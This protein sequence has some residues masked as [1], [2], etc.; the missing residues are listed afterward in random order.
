MPQDKQNLASS[1]RS[2]LQEGQVRLP[3]SLSEFPQVK[4]KRACSGL[5]D[6]H[7]G[8][9]IRQTIRSLINTEYQL[10]AIGAP[11]FESGMS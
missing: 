10:V 3:D 4:Q 8:Q 11:P 5:S 7:F 1:G 6:L 2:A 9:R